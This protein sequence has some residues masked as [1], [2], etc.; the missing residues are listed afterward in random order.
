M[1]LTLTGALVGTPEY[2]APEQAKGQ[3]ADAQ[4]DIYA[5]GLI[6]YELLTGKLPYAADSGLQCVL[7]RTHERAVPNAPGFVDVIEQ[8]KAFLNKMMQEGKIAV[9]GPFP[10]GDAGELRGVIIFRVGAE[11][12]AKLVQD[13]PTV[14]AGLLKPE[15][16]P[17]ITGKGVP[18]ERDRMWQK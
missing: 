7:K 15:I 1:G 3:P 6:F 13:D 8:H 12:T 18:P 4:S 14:R 2:M 17:W 5:A 10:F 16:H 11:Q 9:A